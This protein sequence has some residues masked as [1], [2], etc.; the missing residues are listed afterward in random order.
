MPPNWFDED[1]AETYDDGVQP[2]PSAAIEL[3][4]R[5]AAPGG[6]A[7]EFAI[8]TGR[9][10]LPLAARGVRVE[11]VEL[12]SA[13]LA[14][15]R[16]KPGGDE[17]RIPA[18]V[19]DMTTA[20]RPGPFDVV[21]LVFNTIMNLTAQAAQAACFANAAQHL[22][23]GGAFLV[24]TGIPALRLLPPGERYVTVEVTDQH[25]CV[26]EYDV[27]TQQL[28]SHHITTRADGRVA[29]R[30]VPF[31]YV[32]PAELD[33]MAEMAG[34]RLQ[35]RWADWDQTPLSEGS[36]SHISIWTKD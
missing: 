15:L 20:S 36:E 3:L 33:L 2:P 28:V 23:S 29:R 27:L 11:G 1:V 35:D 32:W 5:L 13:M 14:R 19:G 4:T 7:L 17:A 30:S 21:F 34:L 16:A 25:L 9:F 31:R 8:G 26:D 10:A 18:V 22:R 24:E 6:R 12:S